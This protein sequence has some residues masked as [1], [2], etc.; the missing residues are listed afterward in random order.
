MYHQL[1]SG[2]HDRDGS[3]V[4]AEN[5]VTIAGY[6]FEE[7]LNTVESFHGYTA[8][9]LIIGGFMVDLALQKL[10]PNTL[11]DAISETAYCLPD[12]IQILTPCTVGNGWLK[13]FDFSRF[14]LSLYDKYQGKGVRVFLDANKI[15]HRTEIKNWFFKL[16]KK[17]EQDEKLLKAQ[18]R[19][20]GAEICSFQDVS[21]QPRLLQKRHK[22]GIAVCSGCGEA[23]PR[24]HGT[25]CRA[26]QG[27][28]PYVA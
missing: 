9:G 2:K 3:S 8:P 5:S 12:A 11:F 18:I 14:A 19:E 26:C 23:Y 28:T 21:I 4:I 7:Y 20:A 22:G 1:I 27:Q 10:P 6:S 17:Q 24:E 16:T 15:A 13:I 25:V